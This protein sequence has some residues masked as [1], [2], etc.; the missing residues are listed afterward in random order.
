MFFKI[1]DNELLEIKKSI[2]DIHNLLRET[3]EQ[4]IS[5]IGAIRASQEMSNENRRDIQLIKEDVNGLRATLKENSNWIKEQNAIRQN[6]DEILRQ[7][8]YSLLSKLILAIVIA[9][10][11]LATLGMLYRI[12][13]YMQ[14]ETSVEQGTRQ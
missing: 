11:G 1:P 9:V 7:N 4:Y 12:E 3:R 13:Q 6:R 5:E 14:T 10:S 2:A 8:F